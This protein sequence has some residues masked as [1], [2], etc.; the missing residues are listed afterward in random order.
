MSL[1]AE[2]QDNFEDIEKQ[3][4]VKAVQ[5]MTTYWSILEKVPGSKLRLTKI[6]DEIYEHFKKEFPDYDAKA[7]INEDE[8]KSKAGKD[9]WRNFINQYENK[10]D[11]YNF[12]TLLRSNPAFEYG[13]DETIFADAK[14]SAVRMQFYALEIL[15]NRE[16]LNDW[17][18]E[19]AQ[20]QK[21]S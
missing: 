3:F 13:Q 11:D 20:G 2:Q 15:R 17:I 12:G 5:H 1:T 9:R 10:V 7:T 4:A 19:K 21:A 6:D 16:G 18:Y 14:T 8:M